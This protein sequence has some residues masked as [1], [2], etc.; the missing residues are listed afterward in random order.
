MVLILGPCPKKDRDRSQWLPWRRFPPTQ[1]ESVWG[2]INEA[3]SLL[4]SWIVNEMASSSSSSTENSSHF[5]FEGGEMGGLTR[6]FDWS[7]T[8]IG[9]IGTWPQSLRTILSVILNS[10]FPMF[11]WWGPDLIQFYNDAYRP[12]LGINGKHP[13]ALGERGELSWPEIW[14]TIKP[15]ID[16]VLA[17]GE[18]TWSEDQLI[19]IHRNGKIED[20]YWTFSFSP[21]HDESGAPG[22]VLVTCVE[23]TQ[24]V[25]TIAQLEESANELSFAIEATELATWDLDPLTNR[26]RSNARLKEWFGLSADEE[27]ELQLALDVIAEKDRQRVTEAI[28]RA[29]EFSSG[30]QYDVEYSI[31]HPVTKEERYVRAKG[32]AWFND[33]KVAYRFNG[34]LQDVTAAVLARKRLEESESRFRLFVQASNDTLYKMSP[35]WRQMLTLDGGDFLAVTD[36][37]KTNW[38]EDYLPKEDQARTL[39]T[40]QEAISMKRVFELEHRVIKADGTIGWTSSRAIP[41]FDQDGEITEWFGAATDTTEQKLAR[42]AMEESEQRFRIMAD[43]APNIVW[44]LNPDASLKYANKYTL[45][46]IGISMEEFLVSNWDFMVHPEDLDL[47]LQTVGAAIEERKMYKIE[48]RLLRHD[49][50][51]RWMLTQGAPSYFANGELY[52]YVGSSIDITEIKIAEEKL[53][54][55]AAE[56]AAANQELR[57]SHGKL[58]STVKQLSHIN[59]DLDNFIYTA[60]HDLRAPISNIEGLMHAI[61]EDLSVESRKNPAIENLFGLM[62]ASIERFKRTVH[63]LTVITKIQRQDAAEGQN[64]QVDL[65]RVTEEVLL[66][67]SAEVKASN[68]KV[69]VDLRDC[70][71]V[72]FSSKNARSIVYNLISNAIKYRSPERPLSLRITCSQQGSYKVLTVQDNGLGMD[73]SDEGKVFGMFRRLH[74]H[75]EGSGVGLYIVKKIIENAGGRIEVESKVNVGTTFSVFFQAVLPLDENQPTKSN[76]WK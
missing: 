68:A 60:S 59:S 63:E 45:E 40:I 33:E 41:V 49:G 7:K 46:F 73:A 48:Q 66:D 27:M 52:G 31:I 53:Q 50:E 6:A 22:G 13:D 56:L 20:V 15:L 67:F 23:T 74:D 54:H 14:P 12:S 39:E 62:A 69:E 55:I 28:N 2:T 19:P 5:P 36:K 61:Q 38:I 16:R 34:T 72:V 1:I 29:N 37:P 3:Y 70:E 17:G 30:G 32:R 76:H 10:K 9:P 42:E 26:L 11:L 35:D 18:A 47:T 8:P 65:S 51:Y 71:P 75:V 44:A 24:K 4:K 64:E 25:L 57:S 21:V 58:T 43:A